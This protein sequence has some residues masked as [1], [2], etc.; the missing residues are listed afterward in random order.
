MTAYITLRTEINKE[1]SVD[2]S[3]RTIGSIIGGVLLIAF[4]LLA[5]ASQLFRGFNFWGTFW[6]LILIG[7]GIVFFAGMFAAGRSGGGLAIPGAIFSGIGLM[8]FFQNLTNHWESWSYGWTVIV[9]SVGVGIYIAGWWATSES[10]KQAGIRV[11]T[12]GL[13]L[14][15]IFG[16]FFEMIFQSSG[17]AQIIFPL[18]LVALGAYLIFTRSRRFSFSPNESKKVETPKKSRSK[19]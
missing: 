4:G 13:I 2:T 17:L 5:L 8:M 1:V 14:F 3:N 11:F 15:V 12:I 16:A 9:M 7:I 18:A 19:K 6:P 10:Q